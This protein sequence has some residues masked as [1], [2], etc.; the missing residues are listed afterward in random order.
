MSGGSSMSKAR[1]SRRTRIASRP[2][3]AA[4]TSCRAR[5]PGPNSNETMSAAS[6][7]AHWCRCRYDPVRARPGIARRRTSAVTSAPVSSGRSA[8]MI[9]TRA[10][11]CASSATTPP[12]TTSFSPAPHRAATRSPA[13]AA[14]APASA[15][16][17]CDR[18]S[19]RE[20]LEHLP[21]MRYEARARL[22]RERL[23]EAL[24]TGAA[25]LHRHERPA[26][27]AA[28]SFAAQRP[29]NCNTSRARRS[30]SVRS[31]SGYRVR[32][33]GS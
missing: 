11:P 30:R 23:G 10:T 16:S 20:R 26:A 3:R 7:A 27:Q 21:S 22:F 6:G 12:A 24:L 5:L 31:P 15:A 17:T 29:A 25:R 19:L 33:S 2:T 4:S 14:L 9:A 18:R 1:P 28:L 8:E 32:C 13:A